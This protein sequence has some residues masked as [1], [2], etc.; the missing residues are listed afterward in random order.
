MTKVLLHVYQAALTIVVILLV[1]TN[2]PGCNT[3]AG[4]G[5]DIYR[6]SKWTAERLDNG[7]RSKDRDHVEH[8]RY[9]HE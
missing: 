7:F 6:G 8:V 2:L 9:A 5:M 1:M 4:L 3:V